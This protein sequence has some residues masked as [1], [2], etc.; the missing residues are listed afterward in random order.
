[1]DPV[2]RWVRD[3]FTLSQA[4]V[5]GFIVLVPLLIVVLISEPVWEWYIGRQEE[6][7]TASQAILDSLIRVWEEQPNEASQR[8]STPDSLG[9]AEP[10]HVFFHF[11]PNA[12]TSSDMRKLGF[13][14]G[15]ATTIVHYREKGGK[16]RIKADVLKIYGLDTSFYNE[17]NDF[18][19][20]PEKANSIPFRKTERTAVVRHLE[21]FDLNQADTTQLREIS[22]IGK[23]LSARIVKYRE[24]LG[25]FVH[26]DQLYEVYGLDSMVVLR[27]K[28]R[29][30][31]ADHF[32]PVRF[33]IN[34]VNEGTL[35][36][37]PYIKANVAR[38]VVTYRFQHG[39]F[40][41]MDDL[42]KIPTMDDETIRKI[43]PYL[44]L[45]D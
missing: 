39:E 33:N 2:R 18:I 28:E 36:T 12:I 6:D 27:L 10:E 40:K 4:Q 31:L 17:L 32:V 24:A 26:P 15:L 38:A 34:K 8:I 23:R 1:M 35:A 29:A 25:G 41:T 20:L 42:R 37:H 45:E 21:V 44:I 7:F 9:R 14:A 5:N 3:F 22:G 19:D 13:S 43:A 30:V 11:D 16:F